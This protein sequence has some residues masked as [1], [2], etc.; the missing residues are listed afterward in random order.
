[1]SR[2]RVLLIGPLNSAGVGGRL[3]EMKVWAKA[4]EQAGADVHVF[5]RFNAAPLF[6]ALS[7]WES[8]QIAFGPAF[9]S[10]PLFT[11]VILRIW[12]SQLLK[13]KRDD[14]F[15][16]A[17]WNRF[18]MGFDKAILF[19]TDASTERQVFESQTNVEI[20]LRFTGT[21][22]DFSR[23][24][25]DSQ[26]LLD[27]PRTY[28]FHDPSLLK[29]FEPELH[30][31]FVDQTAIKE[32]ELLQLPISQQC[33]TFAMVGLFMDVKN[34]EEVIDVFAHFPNFRLLLFG[35]GELEDSYRAK[36]A[37]T[38]SA[39]VEIRG[40]FPADQMSEMFEEFDCLIINSTEETGP[41]TGVEAMAAGKYILS[42]P[43]GAMESRLQ[44][45]A[46]IIRPGNELPD[47]LSSIQMGGDAE[48]VKERERLRQRYIQA[49]SSTSISSKIKEVIGIN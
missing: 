24:K 35:K 32:P 43:V 19:I 20:Y 44:N 14:F 42:T 4:L 13:A 37:S 49:Y 34:V 33:K 30:T 11:K 12:G 36:I 16:S 8:A 39:N 45:S 17:A 47:I 2:P 1:M 3:E 29:G 22:T 18:L 40:F 26:N 31:A 27:F 15:K 48:I 41:M 6:G 7:V 25:K 28:V 10:N 9:F 5:T 23:L 38:E 46:M 21:I